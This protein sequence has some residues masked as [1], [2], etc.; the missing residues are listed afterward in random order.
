MIKCKA[1][2][3]LS[4]SARAFRVLQQISSVVNMYVYMSFSTR[5]L[6]PPADLVPFQI[7]RPLGGSSGGLSTF[8]RKPFYF[9]FTHSG[10]NKGKFFGCSIGERPLDLYFSFLSHN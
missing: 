7:I 3:S 4:C 6:L 1:C 2:K 9:E 10:S 5:K 8:G